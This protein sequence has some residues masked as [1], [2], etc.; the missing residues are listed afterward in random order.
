MIAVGGRAGSDLHIL[1]GSSDLILG[2]ENHGPWFDEADLNRNNNVGVGG[3][4]NGVL[5]GS[6]LHILV[7]SSDLLNAVDIDVHILGAGV[8][9]LV[10]LGQIGAA[11]SAAA[12]A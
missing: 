2:D 8:E 9:V 7:G 4:G 11:P 3:T 6:D 1:V 5:A 10:G 12:A